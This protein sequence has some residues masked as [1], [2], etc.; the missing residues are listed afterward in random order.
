MKN[1]LK[2]ILAITAIALCSNVSAQNLKMAHINMQELIVSMPDYDSAQVKLQKYAK[3]LEEQMEIMQVELNRKYEEFSKNQASWS[4]LVKQVKTDE[5][6]SMNQRFQSFQQQAQEDYQ[7][8]NDKLLQPVIDKA[9]K[10]I[11]AVAK[12]QGI[13]CVLNVQ[14]ILYKDA[15]MTDLLPAVQKHLG[16]VK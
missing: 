10:A 9:N 7:Q 12:T 16:V 8:E 15:T 4:D 13:N 11:E 14:M 6:N 2:F 1:T 5:L 3:G